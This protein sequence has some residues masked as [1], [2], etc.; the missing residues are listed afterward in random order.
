[1]EETRDLVDVVDG[2]K[3]DCSGRVVVEVARRFCRGREGGCGCPGR[4]RVAVLSLA[5]SRCSSED[6]GFGKPKGTSGAYSDSWT[7]D[8]PVI[9]GFLGATLAHAP[10]ASCAWRTVH[11][12]GEQCKTLACHLHR[13]RQY[14]GLHSTILWRVQLCSCGRCHVACFQV[15]LVVVLA[16]TQRAGRGE[17]LMRLLLG[18]GASRSLT[19]HSG[20]YDAT[21]TSPAFRL[22][23]SQGTIDR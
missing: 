22:L 21:S 15:P 1:V 7:A 12:D 6:E 4:R 11:L 14:R 16:L 8:W 19:A 23:L 13:C 2:L 18:E 9:F 17:A 5:R 10:T 3:V 20:Q